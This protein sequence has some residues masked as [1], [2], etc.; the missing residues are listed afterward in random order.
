MPS[1]ASLRPRRV[2]LVTTNDLRVGER[3]LHRGGVTFYSSRSLYDD[4]AVVIKRFPGRAATSRC[5]VLVH[6]IGVSSRYFHPL[7]KE[8]AKSGEVFLIDLAGYG[9]A[10][11]PK[12][13]VPIQL[14]A[15]VLGNFLQRAGVENPVLVGHSMGTQV[16]SQLVFDAPQASDRLV[17]IAPTVNPP[18]RRFSTEAR[19]LL[20]D[21]TR[22]SMRSNLI[23]VTDYLVR[24]GIPYFFAQLTHL[25]ADRIED[26][27]PSIEARTLVLRGDSDP[28]V[29]RSWAETV[30][31]LLPNGVYAEVPGP[32]VV[33]HSD[34]VRIASLIVKHSA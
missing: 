28:I 5:F 12:R 34:P 17:L 20:R 14:H 6:G 4:L 22:E 32:H 18:D 11:D 8:L 30:A 27:L 9:A 33:M 21:I 10:P 19:A 15:D 23:I 24:C 1:P 7:A 13:D 3:M 16:V 26:R 31:E 2:E 29:P 25:M